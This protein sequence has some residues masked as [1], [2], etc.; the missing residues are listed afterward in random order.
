MGKIFVT[1]DEVNDF[2]NY[3]AENIDTPINGVYGLPRGGLVLAVMLSHK[4]G[5]PMLMSPCSNCLIVDDICDT[6]ESLIHYVKNSCGTADGYFLNGYQIATMYYK[7]N[8]LGIKPDIYKYLKGNDW[9]V[10]PW[11]VE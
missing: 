10:F 5:V 11:E 7:D 4:L 3:V 9:I 2:V 8:R 6:G 1:W